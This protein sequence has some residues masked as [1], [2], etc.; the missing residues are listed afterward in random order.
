MLW[1][2]WQNETCLNKSQHEAV[3]CSLSSGLHLQTLLLGCRYRF[4]AHPVPGQPLR[5]QIPGSRMVPTCGLSIQVFPRTRQDPAAPGSRPAWQAQ[6]LDLPH[7]QT[8]PNSP[9]SPRLQAHPSY[10]A[11]PE[12]LVMRSASA[13]I[14]SVPTQHQASLYDPRFHPGFQTIPEP[15]CPT[16]PQ[17]SDHSPRLQTQTNDNGLGLSFSWLTCPMGLGLSHQAGTSGHRLQDFPVPIW[18]LQ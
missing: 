6:S 18:S 3:P 9:I 12:A 8:N 15:G 1:T 11:G 14:G 5:F 17:T 2:C 16:Q 7:H 10:Q 4:Q 13:G